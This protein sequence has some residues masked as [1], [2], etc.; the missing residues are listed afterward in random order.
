MQPSA[1]NPVDYSLVESLA[2]NQHRKA[3]DGVI[4]YGTAGFRTKADILDH[5]LFRMG[6]L[7]VL[8]SQV[9]K[10]AIGLMITA[11]HNP[12]AD[13]GVKLVDPNGEMLESSW[14][15]IATR[16]ANVQ[17]SQVVSTLQE[18]IKEQNID[19]SYP[20]SVIIGRDT[21][22]SSLPLSQAA[23]EGVKAMNGNLKDFGV[24]TTPQLHY[25]VHCTN[26]NGAYGVPTVEG[27]YEKIS[28]A[29]KTA[30]GD[31]KDND[32]YIGKVQIDAANGVGALAVKE[33]KK[34]LSDVIDIQ[35]Y[36]D[37]NGQLNHMCGADYVKIQQIPPVN[38]PLK[39]L[40]RSVS[41]D[42]D[43]DR[44]V[45]Y[46]TD[47]NNK[48]HLLDGD[49]IAIL[50]AAHF[51][52]LLEK[53]NLDLQLGLVQTAYAN[54]GSTAYISETLALIRAKSHVKS[55]LRSTVLSQC[56]HHLIAGHNKTRSNQNQN[57][58]FS[59]PSLSEM[60]QE[61]PYNSDLP[62]PLLPP[63]RIQ[64]DSVREDSSMELINLKNKIKDDVNRYLELYKKHCT[65][66]DRD[67]NKTSHTMLPRYVAT[68]AEI[69]ECDP[70]PEFSGTYNW[71]YTGG[72][73]NGIL[74]D[75]RNILV[76]PYA[77]ELIALPVSLNDVSLFKPDFKN[78][79][80]VALKRNPF[81]IVCS[82]VNN[83]GR[84]LTRHK[85]ECCVYNIF[86]M[87][88]KKLQ[89]LEIDKQPSESSYISAD[90][91]PANVTR[92]C[93]TSINRSITI[94]DTTKFRGILS[95]KVPVTRF[96]EDSW[97]FIKYDEYN[98]NIIKYVDRHCVHYYD[99]RSPIERPAL[100]MCP[101]ESLEDWEYLSSYIGSC[102]SEYYSYVGS[103]LSLCLLDSRNP[104][105]T[106]IKKW[107]HQFKSSPLFTDVCFRENKEFVIIASQ[108]PG[109]T[110]IILNSWNSSEEPPESYS[111]PFSPP[112]CIETLMASHSQGKCL[113]PQLQNRLSLCNTGCM[114]TVDTPS[115]DV[116]LLTQ[117]SV[118]DI[119]YQG[120]GHQEQL[121]LYSLENCKALYKLKIWEREVLKNSCH[122]IV[123]PLVVTQRTSARD[124]LRNFTNQK[125]KSSAYNNE[126]DEPFNHNPKWK[127]S[128]AELNTYVDIFAPELLAPWEMLAETPM[129]PITA[130]PH[131]KV[132]S[133]LGMAEKNQEV[134][135]GPNTS[136]TPIVV[137]TQ[138][139]HHQD[140]DVFIT[141]DSES[142]QQLF[143]PKVKSQTTQG[144][145]KKKKRSQYK[146]PVACVPTGVKH[147]HHKALEFDI[148][149]YFEANGH[150]T[151]VFKD[152][153]VQIIRTAADNPSLSENQRTAAHTLSSII[154]VINQTVG[155][156]LSDMLLVELILR[157]KGWDTVA[158]EKSYRDLPNRQVKVK[159][160]DRNA[161]TTTDAERRC[162]TPMGL[163]EKIDEIVAKYP[164]GRS[165]VR[166]SGTE[167]V[168]RVYAEC[169]RIEDVEKL[170]AQ[171]SIAVFELAGGIGTKPV[172]P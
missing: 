71:Y 22:S 62:K 93:T 109:E 85:N 103:N 113:S 8:R 60:F 143:L 75:T 165:F 65:T 97:A 26:T 161:I 116:F 108:I 57:D 118:N 146:V 51:K 68:T 128:V 77:Q 135:T 98:T 171:V 107:T 138:E 148:G 79:S 64:R 70:D 27:Y 44:I 141:H 59:A 16:L 100:T 29:F 124:M 24:V 126:P 53:S 18:I 2:K 167:D 117:N 123:S 74:Y 140:Q 87:D 134:T 120:I 166:P 172:V 31:K 30:V 9:K 1:A 101:K 82:T 91:D 114:A 78:A 43:A 164:K 5:V 49:R 73:L 23:V 13:N 168:V 6:L 12:E 142:I 150:G 42:G 125:L 163:Q 61:F 66:L 137:E 154:D 58:E 169:D 55:K 94:W 17:D 115:G 127:R 88:K 35:I 86:N 131:Q 132:L 3:Y 41:I 50:V 151:I 48:F 83:H 4:Q 40:V 153:A 90:L 95:G 28:K 33:F 14:E 54:G 45:Y 157:A 89:L 10:A 145:K 144:G 39:P 38:A 104:S 130:A 96:F 119:F 15:T 56:S 19:T 84:I 105:S 162:V 152:S 170:A 11:S 21:R 67:K 112:S 111:T 52:E 160:Q 156:A 122:D 69:L 92:Y 133:W 63:S 47:E 149:V 81:Q 102:K 106:V 147:L 110:A 34:Q 159:V 99:S 25:V 7:T 121:D 32:K 139:T 36:N 76:F 46:Y 37:G 158:W 136:D 155:D 129:V 80:K 72:T 20:A